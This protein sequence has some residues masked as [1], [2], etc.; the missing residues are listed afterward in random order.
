V[1][2]EAVA[3]RLLMLTHSKAEMVVKCMDE[4]RLV[5]LDCAPML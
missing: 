1:D 5:N 4:M 3:G 2:R